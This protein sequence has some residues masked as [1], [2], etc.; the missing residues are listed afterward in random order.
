M[1]EPYLMCKHLDSHA[2]QIIGK[3]TELRSIIEARDLL[4]NVIFRRKTNVC[5][6]WMRQILKHLDQLKSPVATRSK[7]F[8]SASPLCFVFVTLLKWFV[9]SNGVNLVGQSHCNQWR[10][11][12]I[13]AV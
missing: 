9:D 12:A 11:K 6:S 1:K 13:A 8:Y 3:R 4:L 7:M 2:V 5:F 10:V